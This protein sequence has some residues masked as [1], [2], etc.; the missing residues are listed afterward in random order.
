MDLKV[1]EP[2]EYVHGPKSSEARR[3]AG[4]VDSPNPRTPRISGVTPAM[5]S[6]AERK[7]IIRKATTGSPASPGLVGGSVWP[8][9]ERSVL[10][11][12]LKHRTT[13][14]FVNS[15]GLA[16]KLTAR[17]NDMHAGMCRSEPHDVVHRKDVKDSPGTT[18]P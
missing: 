2:L 13:L 3:R 11:E 10:D 8:A 17:L 5:E 12:I 7:G 18:I 15:R 6:L 4:G 16:E 14:V 9:I 1:V